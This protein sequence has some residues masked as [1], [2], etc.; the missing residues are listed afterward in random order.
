MA[1]PTPETITL[2][3]SGLVLTWRKDWRGFD[4]TFCDGFDF[5]IASNDGRDASWLAW[6]GDGGH[7]FAG[8]RDECI[9]WLDTRVLDLRAAL[10]PPGAIVVRDDETT[11]EIVERVIHDEIH[12]VCRNEGGH[13]SFAAAVLAALRESAK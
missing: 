1:E 13:K 11:R 10:L 6:I 5:N 7:D 2:P 3:K 4:F 12:C 9:A 8:T